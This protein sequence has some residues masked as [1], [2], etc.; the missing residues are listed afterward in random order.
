M[1]WVVSL[2]FIILEIKIDLNIYFKIT[3]INPLYVTI[4]TIFM[5]NNYVPYWK[6]FSE[7]R[8]CFTFLQISL[9]SLMLDSP[10]CFY[11]PSAVAISHVVWL[12]KFHY[13]HER[14]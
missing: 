1:L 8:H 9:M 12:G 6:I 2:I 4:H 13:I 5:K 11:T 7:K 14:E 3:S 10:I